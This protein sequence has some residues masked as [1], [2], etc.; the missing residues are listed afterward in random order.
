MTLIHLLLLVIPTTALTFL[1]EWILKLVGVRL[2]FETQYWFSFPLAF[3]ASIFLAW[4]VARALGYP[5]LMI[6]SGPCPSCKQRPH[7]WRAD[8]V[9]RDCVELACGLCEERVELWLTSRP[10]ARRADGRAHRYTLRTPKFLGIWR[11]IES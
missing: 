11:R 5:P 4:P 3:I 6:Y 9:S 1:L 7:G 10:S 2:S 8:W